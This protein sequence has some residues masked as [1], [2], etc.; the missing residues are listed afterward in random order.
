MLADYLQLRSS[1]A[2]DAFSEEPV[3]MGINWTN[4]SETNVSLTQIQ[5]RGWKASITV[6]LGAKQID[7]LTLSELHCWKL[8]QESKEL[9]IFGKSWYFNRF[10]KI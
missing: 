10:V 3:A 4:V 1:L 7:S 8:R 5:S 9:F 6:T 2:P